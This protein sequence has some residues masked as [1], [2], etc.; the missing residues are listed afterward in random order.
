MTVSEIKAVIK[1]FKE[2]AW[3]VKR[4]GFD[5]L[6][7]HAAHGYLISQFLIPLSNHRLDEYGGSPERRLRF[8]LEVYSAVRAA[9][10]QKFPIL[11]ELNTID[12]PQDGIT[13]EEALETAKTLATLGI[14]AVEVS[15]GI[16]G[17]IHYTA[18]RKN[19]SQLS[20]EAYFRTAARFFKKELDIPII[21]VGGIRSFEV[22]Q[23]IILNNDADYVSFSRPLICEPELILRWKN[24][25]IRKSQCLSCNQCLR[26]GLKGNGIVCMGQELK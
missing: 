8:L 24:G 11:V 17:S 14:D 20:D 6:Q 4:A 9:V 13:L 22:A 10:G 3:R 23:D 15:G 19:I 16:A 7:L 12:G 25:D 26:E 1:A 18:A 21:L 2:A 5:A